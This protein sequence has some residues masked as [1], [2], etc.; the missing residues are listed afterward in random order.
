MVKI[1]RYF[2]KIYYLFSFV[3]VLL[4]P[5]FKKRPVSLICIVAPPRS[6]STLTY[7]VLTSAFENNHLTNLSNLL[8]ATPVLAALVEKRV[9][10][11]YETI[12]TSKQGFVDGVCG[13]AE[14]LRF[15]SYWMGQGLAEDPMAL[16]GKQLDILCKRLQYIGDKPY[17][18]GYLGHVFGMETLRESFDKVL[19]IHLERDLLS[20]S[21]SLYKL[22][23]NG[24]C[25]TAPGKCKESHYDSIHEQVVDQITQIHSIIQRDSREDTLRV[26]YEALCED[27]NLVIAQIRE[28]AGELGI[29][30]QVKKEIAPFEASTVDADSNEDARI[31]HAFIQKTPTG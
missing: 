5:F 16:N 29:V 24:I 1:G 2:Q 15:W 23:Q 7:Q 6:G 21:Y 8:Y 30:L 18:T 9:C 10:K 3:D 31:L 19:F 27:P 4:I 17:I 13:E 22:S 25:S 26:S 14:G 28:K 20:N 11:H 12:Y